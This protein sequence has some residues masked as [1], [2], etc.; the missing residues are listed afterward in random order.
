MDI[1]RSTKS[2]C[3]IRPDYPDRY[4]SIT[5]VYRGSTPA[6]VEEAIIMRIEEAVSDVVGIKEMCGGASEGSGKVWLEIEDG[7]DKEEVLDQVKDR[8]DFIGTFPIDAERPRV[9]I[10]ASQH[11]RLIA[12]VVS[13]DLNEFDLKRLAESVRDDLLSLPNT[14]LVD[15]KV[16]R[17]YEIDVEVSE[18]TLQRHGLTFD[19]IV[20]AVRNSSTNLSAGSIRAE[21]GDILLLTS[22]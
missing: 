14:T 16:S 4:I 18:S 20:Q 21:G 2:C 9:S 22:N 17:A 19:Q 1:W 13:G 7:Y 3:A 5:V 8:V 10:P 6:E 11:E 15:L 12:A